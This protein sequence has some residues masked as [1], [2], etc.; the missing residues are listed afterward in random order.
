MT[1]SGGIGLRLCWR[2]SGLVLYPY[3]LYH[4]VI[5]VPALLRRTVSL[6][7]PVLCLYF[8]HWN[9]RHG[10]ALNLRYITITKKQTR[11]HEYYSSPRVPTHIITQHPVHRHHHH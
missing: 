3:G 5:F 8:E 10:M 9:L 1:I 6:H 2:S 11:I 7:Y 4:V